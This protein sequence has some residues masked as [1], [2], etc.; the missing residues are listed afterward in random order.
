MADPSGQ[1]AVGD[2]QKLIGPNTPVPGGQKSPTGPQP[3]THAHDQTHTHRKTRTHRPTQASIFRF[4][5]LQDSLNAT[6]YG[7]CR[8]AVRAR[9]F[10]TVELIVRATGAVEPDA[11]DTELAGL[12]LH[13][14]SPEAREQR[15]LRHCVVPCLDR[16][17][18][19]H[20]GKTIPG[21]RNQMFRRSAHTVTKTTVDIT[22]RITSLLFPSLP[23]TLQSS[24]AIR[25]GVPEKQSQVLVL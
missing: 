14:S 21:K 22:T 25:Y 15:I 10:S 8:A 5:S 3:H 17:R 24:T 4:S 18:R 20:A 9:A 16:G 1:Y 23:N 19:T 11:I 13:L 7:T 2:A 12:T 6:H